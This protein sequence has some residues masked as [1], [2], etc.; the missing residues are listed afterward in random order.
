MS[1][2]KPSIAPRSRLRKLFQVMII[3]FTYRKG[4]NV[5]KSKRIRSC[6]AIKNGEEEQEEEEEEG[7]EREEEVRG[8]D[9]ISNNID[10]NTK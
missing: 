8:G 1:T 2:A 3:L 5:Q 4:L 9:I 10:N 7:E 6:K